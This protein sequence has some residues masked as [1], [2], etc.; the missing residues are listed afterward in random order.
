NLLPPE[1]AAK[2]SASNIK[3]GIVLITFLVLLALGAGIIYGSTDRANA[4]ERLA[5]LQDER[6][7]LANTL[8]SYDYL[9]A[10]QNDVGNA[11]MSR[12]WV[13]AHDV[14]WADIVLAMTEVLPD[15]VVYESLE[16]RASSPLTLLSPPTD[17]Y[18]EPYV[19]ILNFRANSDL[20]VSAADLV[21]ALEAIPGLHNVQIVVVEIEHATA[22][23]YTYW[24]IDG[25][26]E[27]SP[28]AL[29]GRV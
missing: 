27:I 24:G 17:P 16:L 26:I 5:E 9:P 11:L 8:A 21:D 18:S 4:E 3:A 15:D 1:V 2:R 7:E 6:Q 10:L 13:G 28:Q 25:R 19:G 29:S 20:P 23:D 22:Q 14:L 12:Y